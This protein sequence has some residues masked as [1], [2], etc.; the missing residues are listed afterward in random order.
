[1]TW[2]DHGPWCDE[3]DWDVM[4]RECRAAAMDDDAIDA[5]EQRREE[6]LP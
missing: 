2:N 1:M 3:G 6:A 5:A 4:C